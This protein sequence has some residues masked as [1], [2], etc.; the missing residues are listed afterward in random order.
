L[1]E[2]NTKD[3]GSNAPLQSNDGADNVLGATPFRQKGRKYMSKRSGQ[4]G[5]V[6]LRNDRWVGRFYVDVPE[7]SKRKRRALVLG[8]KRELNRSE[9][10]RKLLDIIMQQG[11]NTPTHLERS[12]RPPTTFA[13]VA[14]AWELKRLPQLKP[15]SRYTAPK[16]IAKYLRPWFGQTD[17]EE[18]KTG[19]VNDWIM[20]LQAK[21]LQPKTIHNLWKLFRAIMNWHSQQNDEPTRKWY[22]SLPTLPDVEQRW[23]TQLEI[24]QIVG[25]AEGQYR[26][27]FHLAG[28]SGMRAGELFGLHVD[29]LDMDRGVIHVRRSVWHGQEVPP[30]TRK[31]YR[32]VWI[33]SGTVRIIQEYL[34][35]RTSGRIFQTR[36][37]TPLTDHDV[38]K[39]VLHPICDNLKIAR[40]GM[41]A[42]RHGRVSHM[43]QNSVPPDFT[44]SQVGHS[45]L[46]TT[47]G[48][49]HFSDSFKREIVEQL[50][51]SWTHSDRLDSVAVD[52]KRS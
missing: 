25:E 13:D 20:D 44:K 4:T 8:M 3:R 47:S 27:L 30:K 46:R 10:K 37:G 42:F 52:T 12:Q 36:N 32:E 14:D 38:L 21:S 1:L 45:S 6:F 41:H 51:P 43:Q 2:E 26:V 28:S 33:D 35:S 23:F 50:A 48:Y 17:L 5:Q 40:G 9:A 15:S 18:I 31:G 11:V 24:G 19:T 16:L 39:N 22:P 7:A 29:D 49:T 34:G